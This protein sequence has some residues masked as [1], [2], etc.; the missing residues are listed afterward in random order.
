MVDERQDPCAYFKRFADRQ[1]RNEQFTQDMR[2]VMYSGYGGAGGDSPGAR[3]RSGGR[4]A[5]VGNAVG[6]TRSPGLAAG[7]TL[8]LSGGSTAAEVHAEAHAARRQAVEFSRR[9]SCPFDDHS[10]FG[11]S[12]NEFAQKT[13][14]IPPLPT[15]DARVASQASRSLGRHNRDVQQRVGA[16]A[17]FDAPDREGSGPNTGSGGAT[18]GSPP[19]HVQAQTFVETLAEAKTYK[20]RMRGTED[21]IAGNYVVGD[22]SAVQ[23]NRSLPP[24][25]PIALLPQAHMKLQYDGGSVRELSQQRATYLNSKVLAENNRARNGGLLHL[26]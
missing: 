22:G 6:R 4:S 11:A 7:A 20:N 17:P 15:D 21:L 14:G 23:R 8:A 16:G 10:A 2:K 9:R 26:G 5:S 18:S 12:V 19:A 25:V 24:K 3:P 1:Q 13:Q